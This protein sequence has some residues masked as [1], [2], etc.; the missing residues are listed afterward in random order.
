MFIRSFLLFCVLAVGS[1]TALADAGP[2]DDPETDWT[3][4]VQETIKA[5]VWSSKVTP[6][7]AVA[8]AYRDCRPEFNILM[9]SLP[10]QT[11][12]DAYRRNVKASLPG[13]VAFAKRMAKLRK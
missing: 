1:A 3:Y 4:C 6:E 2:S 8:K 7:K 5:V 11:S 10:N 13:E 9:R 12:R